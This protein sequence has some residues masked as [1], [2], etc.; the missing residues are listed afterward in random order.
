MFFINLKDD[1]GIVHMVNT[2]NIVSFCAAGGGNIKS[3]VSLSN[4][5]VLYSQETPVAIMAL[6]KNTK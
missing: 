5:T 2:L 6:I 3:A 1:L 4:G